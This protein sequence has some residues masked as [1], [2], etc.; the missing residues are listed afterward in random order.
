MMRGTGLGLLKSGKK[1]KFLQD[2]DEARGYVV[3]SGEPGK[4][5]MK[6]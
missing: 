5:V 3:S 1:Q 6:P 4:H 2:T